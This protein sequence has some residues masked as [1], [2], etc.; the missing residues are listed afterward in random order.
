[1]TYGAY[2]NDTDVS[3]ITKAKFEG[4][5]ECGFNVVIVG[6]YENDKLAKAFEV[7]KD[8]NIKFIIG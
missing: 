4:I 5:I 7:A 8:L 1:M 2:N 3:D 6:A